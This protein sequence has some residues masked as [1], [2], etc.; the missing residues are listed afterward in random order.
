MTSLGAAPRQT[1]VRV[2]GVYDADG[3]ARGELAY[4]AVSDGSSKP[5]RVHMRTPSFGNLQALAPLIEGCLLADSIA[6]MGSIDFVLGDV[7][8]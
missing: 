3:T 8:R 5:L 4:Y 7:D 6:I 2:V 1:V